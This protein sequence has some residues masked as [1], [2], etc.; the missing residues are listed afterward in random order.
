MS[1]SQDKISIDLPIKLNRLIKE[2][3]VLR[4]E[5]RIEVIDQLDQS[6]KLHQWLLSICKMESTRQ[7]KLPILTLRMKFQ[8]KKSI[9]LNFRLR[10]IS[11][12]PSIKTIQRCS[13]TWEDRAEEQVL[14]ELQ[15]KLVKKKEA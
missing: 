13:R 12:A 5:L 1:I 9:S 2:G 11:F 3:K 15:D 8:L 7:I 6:N 14:T 4:L 10:S